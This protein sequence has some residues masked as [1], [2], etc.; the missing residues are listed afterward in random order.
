MVQWRVTCMRRGFMS[1]VL[2]VRV[3]FLGS[4]G[5]GP[6]AQLWLWSSVEVVSRGQVVDG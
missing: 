4:Q 3:F 5:S 1:N 2:L 6:V